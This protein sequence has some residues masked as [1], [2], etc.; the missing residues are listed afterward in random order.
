M[1]APGAGANARHHALQ[2]ALA[3]L[4]SGVTIGG[5]VTGISGLRRLMS[6]P[7]V[8]TPPQELEMEMPVPVKH[9]ADDNFPILS[10]RWWGSEHAHNPADVW[11]TIPSSVIGAGIGTLGMSSLME[12]LVKKKRKAMMNQQFQEAQTDFQKSLLGQYKQS[13]ADPL[14]SVF[15]K[16]EKQ[17]ALIDPVSREI[18]TKLKD[19]APMLVGGGLTAAGILAAIA[20]RGAYRSQESRTNEDLLNKALKNRSYLQSMRSP[21]PVVFTPHPVSEDQQ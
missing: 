8:P 12:H 1:A 5:T 4:L 2:I 10:K 19:Y 15:D 6:Q 3:S 20:A 18:S 21:P 16:I 14:D 11:W 7:E 9:A 13:S 17:S